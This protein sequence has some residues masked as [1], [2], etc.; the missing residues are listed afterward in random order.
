MNIDQRLEG[1]TQTV[2]LLAGFQMKNEQALAGLLEGIGEL[3]QS[4]RETQQ[5][6][7]S[8]ARIAEIHEHR[9][10]DLEDNRQ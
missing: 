3:R 9:I 2:E 7:N 5:S 1:L 10:S 4:V 8:L 6:V